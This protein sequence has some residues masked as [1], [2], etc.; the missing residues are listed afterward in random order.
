MACLLSSPS[1]LRAAVDAPFSMWAGDEDARKA[2]LS[3]CHGHSN[4]RVA[5]ETLAPKE[6]FLA[7]TSTRNSLG[8]RPGWGK[9]E[10]DNSACLHPSSVLADDG[11]LIKHYFRRLNF[12]PFPKRAKEAIMVL[13]VLEIA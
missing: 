11:K 12:F 1:K 8:A 6:D 13:Q 10:P 7:T 5:F 2:Q 3:A 4:R 9:V